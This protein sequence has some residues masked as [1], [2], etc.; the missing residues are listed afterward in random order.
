MWNGLI[1]EDGPELDAVEVSHLREPVQ[2]R[3]A[4][5][6]V[7]DGWRRRA[8]RETKPASST[9][10][11]LPECAQ[12]YPAGELDLALGGASILQNGPRE[13]HN[14]GWDY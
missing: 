13:L 8:T 1:W 5:L 14:V 12:K 4:P 9:L 7:R 6:W 2:V 11:T 3:G 10:G